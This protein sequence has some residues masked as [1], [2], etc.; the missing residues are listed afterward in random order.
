MIKLFVIDDHPLVIQGIQ[1]MLSEAEDMEVVG[2]AQS[3]AEGRALLAQQEIDILILDINLP[4][5]DGL[6]LCASL[7]TKYPAL[8]IIALTTYEEVSFVRAML[9]AGAKGYLFKTTAS[10]E[11]FA[12]IRTV[13]QGETYLSADVN[14]KLIASALH[15]TASNSFI[16]K[17]TR[18][19]KEVL[20]LIMAEHTNQEIA[21]LLSI[22]VST[23]ETHRTHLCEKLGARN[24]AG[25]VKNAIQMGLA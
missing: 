2:S 9:K 6:K 1:A 25:L 23:V 24:T 13:M 12:A 19:E 16:P 21:A 11:F 20:K 7:L 17:L 14:Q 8:K 3:A 15:Q 22:A 10:K 5:N 4:D 18:R